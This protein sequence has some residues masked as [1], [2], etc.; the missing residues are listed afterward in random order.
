[1]RTWI[2]SAG[3][4]ILLPCERSSSSRC[5]G[6]AAS[7]LLNNQRRKP[8]KRCRSPMT[9]A[10]IHVGSVITGPLLPEPVEVL[11]VVSLGDSVKLIGKGCKTGL[12]REPI[13]NQAQ[14][15]QLR[16]T[17]LHESFDGDPSLFRLGIEAH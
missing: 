10:E 6:E 1:M 11:A 15:A 7:T 3:W 17:P 13:L 12:V 9:V 4:V 16:F 14:L 5:Y 8:P 2:S